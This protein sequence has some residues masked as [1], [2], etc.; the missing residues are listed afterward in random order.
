MNV[1]IIGDGLTSLSL[2]KNLINKKINVHIYH[3]KKINN[4]SLNRTIGISKNNLDFF[5]NEIS[6]FSLKDLWEIKRIEIYSQKLKN[7][8]IINFENDNNLF[9]MIKNDQFY[10]LLNSKLSKSKFFKKIIIKKDNFYVKLLKE[11][12]Y[13]LIIN[14]DSNNFLSKKYFSKKID[15]DYSNLA[16]TTILEHEPLENNVAVQIFTKFGPIAYLPISKSKTSDLLININ[17]S[18]PIPKL[19]SHNN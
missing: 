5:E 3:K 2:A 9:Y 19:R 7:S 17:P 10:K 13:N 4:L 15:K 14:C 8:K 12:N 16:Y 6:R 1:C 18:E 11:K